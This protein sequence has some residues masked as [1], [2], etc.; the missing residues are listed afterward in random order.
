MERETGKTLDEWVVIAKTCPET[1]PNARKAWF[2]FDREVVCLGADIRCSTDKPV[3]T[4]V[5]Q[6]LLHGKVH[7]GDRKARRKKALEHP[8]LFGARQ[9]GQCRRIPNPRRRTP[10]RTLLRQ[11]QKRGVPFHLKHLAIQR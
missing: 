11:N 6:C 9:T 3:F 5:N 8:P 2:C 4:S 10:L 1:K 7:A